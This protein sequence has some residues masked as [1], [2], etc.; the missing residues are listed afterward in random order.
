M[1]EQEQIQTSGTMPKEE[2]VEEEERRQ[3]T[4]KTTEPI[5]TGNS[6]CIAFFGSTGGC[7]LAA[8]DLALKAGFRARARQ[9]PYA[10]SAGILLTL[11]KS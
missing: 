9:V 7:T 3:K 10:I 1:E 5:G 8:L 11:I 6:I 2:V 4:E